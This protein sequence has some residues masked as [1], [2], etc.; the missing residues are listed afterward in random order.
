MT[1]YLYKCEIDEENFSQEEQEP[2]RIL[3]RLY[4]ENNTKYP[5]ILLK[6]VVVSA[7]MS[8]H[9]LGPKL[10]GIFPLGRLEELI[11]AKSMEQ[12]DMYDMVLSREIARVMARFHTLEM[13][14]IKEPQWLFETT[15]K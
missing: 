3:L 6:D 9:Q 12:N 8:D 4:G 10:H 2:N 5:A 15:Q 13:P 7:I 14:F 1:N 11:N